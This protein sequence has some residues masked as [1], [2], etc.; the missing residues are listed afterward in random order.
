MTDV[1]TNVV[2]GAIAVRVLSSSFPNY[3]AGFLATGASKPSSPAEAGIHETRI[4]LY[5]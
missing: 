4:P 5:A 1:G 3:G 2:L